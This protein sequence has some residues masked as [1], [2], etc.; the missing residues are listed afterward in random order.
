M[1]N[2]E[3]NVTAAFQQH[4]EQRR[5]NIKDMFKNPEVAMGDIKKAEDDEEL[6]ETE[7]TE[8]KEVKKGCGTEIKKEKNPEEV[9]DEEIEDEEGEDDKKTETEKAELLDIIGAKQLEAWKSQMDELADDD[10]MEQTEKAEKV[11]AIENEISDFAEVSGIQK[12]DILYALS[13]YDTKMRFHKTGKEIKA[14]LKDVVIP[15]LQSNLTAAEAKADELLEECG[16]APT[17]AVPEYWTG[18]LKVEIPYKFYN[19]DE[20]QFCEKGTS[21]VSSF[22]PDSYEKRCCKNAPE[23][24]EQAE[25]RNK[26]NEA[27]RAIANITT[28]IKTCEI[29]V[30]NLKDKDSVE[31]NVRQL[32]AFRFA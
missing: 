18:D 31:L 27:V 28:D 13:G 5:R 17:N 32:L 12:S 7:E 30:D 9:M 16:T 4:L 14:Q 25:A 24:A 22:S 11:A 10:T 26:Y 6:D 2:N 8:K 20:T 29:I 19:W 15:E 3:M 21:L 1:A 23:N